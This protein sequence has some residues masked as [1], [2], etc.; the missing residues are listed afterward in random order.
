[1]KKNFRDLLNS[2]KKV[3]GTMMHLPCPE[4]V[5]IL[6]FS[7]YDYVVLD[8]EHS[9][10]T[11]EQTVNM[12][13]AADSAGLACL[14]RVPVISE[15]AIKKVL[16]MGC[17]GIKVP[18]V[19]TVE[20]AKLVVKHAKY[21]PLGSRGACPF[22]RAN[23]YGCNE[24]N[25]AFYK[26]ENENIV[27][28]LNIEGPEGV[29]NVAEII[30]LE[31]VDAVSVGRMDLS[32]ALGIPGEVDH[33]SVKQAVKDVARIAHENGKFA[34]VFLDRAEDAAEFKDSPGVNH[35]LTTIP[36]E[37]LYAGYK[38]LREDIRMQLR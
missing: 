36:E 26:R 23:R 15:D 35:F 22:V 32:V 27:L 9:P 11:Y 31:G 7:G 28:S 38:K 30:G 19:S 12:I 3:V 14:V 8:T 29:K 16:D 5:E 4:I 37:I 2:G 1:M 25:K 10:A 13:R 17:S 33:P 21:A 20:E 6:A 18:T 34:G 24:N